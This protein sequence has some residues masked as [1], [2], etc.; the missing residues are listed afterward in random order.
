MRDEDV[1]LVAARRREHCLY[2]LRPARRDLHVELVRVERRQLASRRLRW[3]RDWR[4]A[5]RSLRRR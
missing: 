3:A 4:G 5:G 2:G 1:D